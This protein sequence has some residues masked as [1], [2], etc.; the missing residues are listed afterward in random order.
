MN[1]LEEFNIRT[2]CKIKGLYIYH[3]VGTPLT[4]TFNE[5][6]QIIQ[7]IA[8]GEVIG[9]SF[10]PLTVEQFYFQMQ[11]IFKKVLKKTRGN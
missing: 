6:T 5:K 4:Y 2:T 11:K 9:E 3:A 7:S 8:D 10:A 1:A